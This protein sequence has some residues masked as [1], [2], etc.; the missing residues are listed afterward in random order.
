MPKYF[1]PTC[2]G[3]QLQHFDMNTLVDIV[4]KL[5]HIEEPRGVSSRGTSTVVSNG[6]IITADKV[7]I[8]IGFWDEKAKE[9]QPMKGKVI[10]AYGCSVVS[11]SDQEKQVNMRG[12][13]SSRVAVAKGEMAQGCED[14]SRES[15]VAVAVPE[16]QK[17]QKPINMDLQGFRSSLAFLSVCS[18]RER[19]KLDGKESKDDVTWEVKGATVRLDNSRLVNQEGDLWV[20]GRA[21]DHT[22]LEVEVQF[23]DNVMKE[24]TGVDSMEAAKERAERGQLVSW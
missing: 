5:V 23:Q 24:M 1:V 9:V 3:G 10:V 21:M 14:L 22:S 20:R 17:T 6:I 12:R 13:G 4:G 19:S 7:A 15:A 2:M 11:G 18:Q 8:S 16:W